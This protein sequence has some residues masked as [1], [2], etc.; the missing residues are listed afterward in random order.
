ML[1]TFGYTSF[2]EAKIIK[3]QA[4]DKN[5]ET[6]RQ[7]VLV[8]PLGKTIVVTHDKKNNKMNEKVVGDVHFL[9]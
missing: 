1:I 5:G 3:M 2:V 7:D 9:K 8:H 4:K 6:K